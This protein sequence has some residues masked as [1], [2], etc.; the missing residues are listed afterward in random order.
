MTEL[1]LGSLVPD[2]APKLSARE[3][4]AS[5]GIR[6]QIAGA[7][8]ENTRKDSATV[9]VNSLD[10]CQ[11]HATRT[12][13]VTVQV[14][15][16]NSRLG[17]KSYGGTSFRSDH[18]LREHASKDQAAGRA[19]IEAE[20]RAWAKSQTGFATAVPNVGRLSGFF[21]E[22]HCN[23]DCDALGCI[24]GRVT[25]PDCS[26]SLRTRCAAGCDNGKTL[27]YACGGASTILR[28]CTACVGG[29]VSEM[30]TVQVW[31]YSTNTSRIDYVTEYV[32]CRSCNGNHNRL[33]RCTSCQYGKI[34]CG[35]CAGAGTVVCR[36]CQGGKINCS[37]CGGTGYTSLHY[38][39]TLDI[40]VKE[41]IATV[42]PDDSPARHLW[43][44]AD[45]IASEAEAVRA[46]RHVDGLV[47]TTHTDLQ[48]P[49]AKGLA[50]IDDLSTPFLAAGSAY[51]VQDMAG[52]L[53]QAMEDDI[54]DVETAMPGSRDDAL[55]RLFSSKFG[56]EALEI[57]AASATTSGKTAA[58][59]QGD[60][61]TRVGRVLDVEAR[62]RARLVHRKALP[63]AATATAA[64]ALVFPALNHYV[65]R[66]FPVELGVAVA[67]GMVAL[68]ANRRLRREGALGTDA[69]G[70]GAMHALLRAQRVHRMARWAYLAIAVA[71]ITLAVKLSYWLDDRTLAP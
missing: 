11:S 59:V 3:S 2:H 55:R 61:A 4:E 44:D 40:D 21:N 63:I 25:C 9:E 27:C 65:S 56:R 24:H 22:A 35:G 13:V 62:A 47:L 60:F 14:G 50:R 53:A 10:L 23:T 37:G 57:H 6:D 69:G 19:A 17:R 46:R 18:E 34:P 68:W 30:R 43:S 15:W 64:A 58:P 5:A 26:G 7:V 51:A 45:F 70:V 38:L 20:L 67:T 71:G 32:T 49:Y 39:P 52:I 1:Q 8:Y 66:K 28:L 42:D 29:R 41:S 33:E 48:F 16:H 12:H 31:D 36:R 54:R